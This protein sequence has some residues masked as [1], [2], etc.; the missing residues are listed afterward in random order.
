[1]CASSL[2]RVKTSR[3]VKSP[4]LSTPSTPSLTSLPS[5]FSSS[6]TQ[7]WLVSASRLFFVVRLVHLSSKSAPRAT[8]CLN[9]SKRRG[10]RVEGGLPPTAA[11]F[12]FSSFER[13]VSDPIPFFW[14][15]LFLLPCRPD[16]WLCKLDSGTSST[17]RPP[18]P[19]PRPPV[20]PFRAGFARGACL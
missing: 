19:L 15:L 7:W 16:E 5:L 14:L 18:S 6:M 3:R 10:S 4:S 1:M 17:V 13:G 11:S 20:D 2:G 12:P 9:V 8:F